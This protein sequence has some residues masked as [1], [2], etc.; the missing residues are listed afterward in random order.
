MPLKLSHTTHYAMVILLTLFACEESVEQT[1][2]AIKLTNTLSE[3]S[4]GNGSEGDIS[5]Y[6]YNFNDNIYA[7]FYL[8]DNTNINLDYHQFLELYGREPNKLIFKNFPE[9][10]AKINP[11]DYFYT[12]RTS[13]DTLPET[14]TILEDTLEILS[15]AY[16]NVQVLEWDSNV[17]LDEQ[18]YETRVS[19]TQQHS[20]F[21]PYLDSLIS[22]SYEAV[23][24]TPLISEGVMFVDQSEWVDTSYFYSTS[25]IPFTHVFEYERSQLNNELL[26]YRINTDCNDN[27]RWDNAG[28]VDNGNGVWDPAEAYFE[29]N[30]QFGYQVDEPFEDRNCNGVRDT[31]ET[32]FD[33]GL[34]GLPNS[35]DTLEG[36]GRYDIGEPFIEFEENAPTT[37]TIPERYTD[38]DEDGE[39]DPNELF[40]LSPKPNVILI[41]W[42]DLNNPRVLAHIEPGDSLVDHWGNIHSNIIE[43][44]TIQDEQN[45][46]TDD[47]DSTVTL[48]TNKVI[49]HLPSNNGGDYFITKTEWSDSYNN[50]YYDYL[51][52]KENEHIYQLV[53]P[54][55]FV[56]EGF[57]TNFWVSNDIVDEVLYYTVNGRLRDGEIIEEDYYDTTSVAIYKMEKRFTV[58]TD[59]I[60]VPARRVKYSETDSSIICL[61]NENLMVADPSECPA[62]DTT[63]YDCFKITRTTTMTLVGNAVEFGIR[64]ITWLSRD[65][66]IVQ[67]ELYIRWTEEFGEDEEIWY[68]VS[69][70][71]LGEFTSFAGNRLG[72]FLSNK[73]Y[74]KL[75]ELGNI[76]EME[77]DPYLINH[78]YGFQRVELPE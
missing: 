75:N 1:D 26:M 43:I 49:E 78:V 31:A 62:V 39:A 15:S 61:A 33:Y 52:F 63:L 71:E 35:L 48:Y 53:H 18:R 5:S 44:V 20:I 38:I 4:I 6:F 56:P 19:D 37:T 58:E 46:F 45:R 14:E 29:N 7:E 25:Q 28:Y 66:G 69:K 36:N 21:M 59:A 10:L 77:N 22:I 23:V 76:S 30:G 16:T 3:T 64:G 9:Y 11:S 54:T 27:G 42:E 72:R 50:R 24:D 41:S 60:T 8:Y 12:Q 47:L 65:M 32:Y 17:T 70:W 2:D 67:D 57:V 55:Y 13:I 74:K 51:L 68:G 34:D 40:V 73:H